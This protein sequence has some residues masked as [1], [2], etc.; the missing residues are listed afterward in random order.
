ME[1]HRDILVAHSGLC[2][3]ANWETTRHT[4]RAAIVAISRRKVPVIVLNAQNLIHCF[5]GI[6]FVVPS[7]A[8]SPSD[9]EN[10]FLR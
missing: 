10:A 7:V 3:P 1:R 8:R 4:M 6:S 9:V 5:H 2:R